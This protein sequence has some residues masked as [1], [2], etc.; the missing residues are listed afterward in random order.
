MAR[1]SK[2]WAVG[3]GTVCIVASGLVWLLVLKG[4]KLADAITTIGILLTAVA[5]GW[6]AYQSRLSAQAS[7]ASAR[8]ARLALAL[9]VRPTPWL[10]L[11]HELGDVDRDWTWYV[12]QTNGYCQNATLHWI[13]DGQRRETAIGSISAAQ[14]VVHRSALLDHSISATAVPEHISGVVLEWEDTSGR[15]RWRCRWEFQN[16][17]GVGGEVEAHGAIVAGFQNSEFPAMEPG[18]IEP[19]W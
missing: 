10:I 4:T 18:E 8:D 14:P 2:G 13:V 5:T 3:A 7:Q 9:H 1:A 17:T 15:M 12:R 16:F 6:A 19:V 11:L